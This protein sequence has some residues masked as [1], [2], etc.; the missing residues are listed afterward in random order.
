MIKLTCAHIAGRDNVKADS[1][2]RKFIDKHEW[3]LDKVLFDGLC[4][5]FGMPDLDLFASRLNAQI[6]RYCAW[7]PDP[8]AL[9]VDAF[10]IRWT[11]VNS[12]YLFPPFSLLGRCVQ[13][14]REEQAKGIVIAPVWK[15][16]PWFSSLMEL[17]VDVPVL[18]RKKKGL[19]RIPNREAE[20]PLLNKMRLMA[21]K[22]SGCFSDN[23]DFLNEQ[24]L[25]SCPPGSPLLEDNMGCPSGGGCHTVI[26]GRLIQF[27]HL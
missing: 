13:K 19:L 11:L 4:R 22:V 1:A 26:Q 21:C 10:S 5:R 8:D 3:M 20:H 16:Q 14:I 25:Y 27:G 18:L 23:K 9:Y 7:K 6:P 15:T 17:L 12:V 24:P 2:S